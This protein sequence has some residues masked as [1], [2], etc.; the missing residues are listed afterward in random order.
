FGRVRIRPGS[1]RLTPAMCGGPAGGRQADALP[2]VLWPDI[3]ASL[4]AAPVC[5]RLCAE[6]WQTRALC[7]WNR[8]NL[9]P[10]RPRRG[11]SYRALESALDEGHPYHPCFK[12][13]TGFSLDDH[14]RYGPEC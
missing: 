6:L 1:L 5:Q 9:G 3:L 10:P 12:A 4:T 2:G 13:R 7:N 11:L 14:R 8:C